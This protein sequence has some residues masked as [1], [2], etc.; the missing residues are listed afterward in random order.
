[1]GLGNP[2]EVVVHYLLIIGIVGTLGYWDGFL[3]MSA[4]ICLITYWT[5]PTMS[6]DLRL[7]SNH[8]LT[9]MLHHVVSQL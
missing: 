6:H 4:L 3:M 8:D 9:K 5:K 2:L 1:M 7:S